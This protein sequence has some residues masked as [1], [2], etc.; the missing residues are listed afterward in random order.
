MMEH[1]H[2]E[3]MTSLAK[4]KKKQARREKRNEEEAEEEPAEERRSRCDTDERRELC[5]VG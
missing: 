1:K 5:P 3:T 2:C 4:A